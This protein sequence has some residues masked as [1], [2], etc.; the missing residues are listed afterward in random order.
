MVVGG[1]PGSGTPLAVHVVERILSGGVHM[2]VDRRTVLTGAA[3]LALA[4]AKRSHAQAKPTIRLGALLDMSGEYSANTGPNA[5][6]CARQA[7]AE[8]NAPSH[9][10]EVELIQADHQNKPDIGASIAR[11]WCDQG[12]DAIVAVPTSSVALAVAEVIKEKNKVMLGSESATAAL[13][14]TQCSPNTVVLSLDTY[15]LA[16]ALGT[17]VVKR[18]G[19]SWFFV[20]ADYTFGHLISEQASEFVKRAGGGVKGIIYHPFPGT[21]D[22]S[23]YLQTAQVSGAQV[24]CLANGGT[25]TQN[26]IKQAHEFGLTETMQIAALIASIQDIHSL[27][28]LGA[29]LDVVSSFYW[30]LNDRTRAF[31]RRVLP[32]MID[33]SYPNWFFASTYSLTL[34]YLKTVAAM[35]AAEAKKNGRDTVARMKGIPTDDDAFGQGRIRADGRGEFSAYLF[36]TKAPSKPGG[37]DLY[38]HL[39]TIPASE[40]LHPLNPK[41]VFQITT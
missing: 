38:E 24:L 40:A 35:G 26:C 7:I 14:D 41:C 31:T 33:H 10:Y 21:T 4:P 32:S 25:D 23:S 8:F 17:A 27:G 2:Y 9:G 39:E 13:T 34:H 12:I 22:F 5:A 20:A 37:W 1:P 6:V 19:K 28:E 18:G 36:R 30:D 29:G 16:Y 11:Q 3:A 15:T